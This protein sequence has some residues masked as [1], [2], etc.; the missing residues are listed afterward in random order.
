MSNKINVF[1]TSMGWILLSLSVGLFVVI[2]G[3][4]DENPFWLPFI[5]SPLL[6]GVIVVGI[7]LIEPLFKKLKI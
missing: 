1:E 2:I 6:V 4:Y 3:K 5:I 7:K